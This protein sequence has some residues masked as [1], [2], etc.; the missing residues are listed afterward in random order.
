MRLTVDYKQFRNERVH[1]EQLD[2]PF[3]TDEIIN[4]CYV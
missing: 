3:T 1:V 2:T 4:L